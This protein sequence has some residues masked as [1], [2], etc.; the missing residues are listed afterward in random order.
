MAA[1]GRPR[2]E[3]CIGPDAPARGL[4]RAAIAYRE[5][6]S[7]GTGCRDAVGPRWH[8]TPCD[9]HRSPPGPALHPARGPGGDRAAPIS[10][11]TAEARRAAESGSRPRRRSAYPPAKG[12]APRPRSGTSRNGVAGCGS[13]ADLDR[14]RRPRH[15][16]A[17]RCA[18]Q[19]GLRTDLL[20]PMALALFL[21]RDSGSMP[22]R[23]WFAP[24]DLTCGV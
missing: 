19:M 11:R 3:P 10:R 23:R 9:R 16:S 18:P 24:S 14:R 21:P 17:V 20:G 12:E 5:V 6:V 22:R 15:R 7:S 4:A 13:R 2:D 8:P 1:R